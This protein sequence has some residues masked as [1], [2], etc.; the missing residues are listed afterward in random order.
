MFFFEHILERISKSIY[1]NNII[2]K[3]G[4]LLTSIIGEEERTTK[5]M[6]AT[7]KGL[8]LEKEYVGQMIKN[9]LCIDINDGIDFEIENIK[10]IRNEDEYG[11]FKIGILGIMQNLKI[12]LFIEL[13][14]GDSITPR[15]IEYSYNCIFEDK[16]I[17][18]FAYTTETV[19]AEKYHSIMTR[20]IFNTRMKDYYDIYVLV[21]ENKE[22]IDFD[23]LNKAIK[24]TYKHRETKLNLE[25]IKEELSVIR[26]DKSLKRLWENYK[27]IA[28]YS[29]EINYEDLFESLDY[30]TCILDKKINN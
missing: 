15:E 27:V 2:L 24:N 29:K 20:G 11:G 10:D 12:H 17:S 26:K 14:T 13:T 1:R 5:D 9:I 16:K 28:P 6:D 7:L 23:N 19:I 8:P 22:K 4:L 30:I 25:D 18:I 21:N 3:G